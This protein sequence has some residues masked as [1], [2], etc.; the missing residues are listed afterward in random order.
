MEQV[1]SP[2][3]QPD[4]A[5]TTTSGRESSRVRR[6][7]RNRFGH[8]RA[9]WRMVF[10]LLA[11]VA[12]VIPLGAAASW[13]GGD[14]PAAAT[15]SWAGSWSWVAADLALI[16]AG[17]F[18]LKFVDRRPIRMLGIGFG[19]GWLR[20]LFV[21]VAGGLVLTSLLVLVLAG[22]GAVS[23]QVVPEIGASLAA[24]PLFLF[25]FTVAA[26]LEELL[27]RGYL[28]Q[29]LAEGS[30]R[31]I[32]AIVLC[33]P[34]TW[35]HA[36]NPDL[37]MVGV[38]NIFLAGVILVILYFQTRRLWLPIGFHLSWN[39]AQ[40]WFWGFDVSGIAIRD[41]LF[42]VTTTGPDFVTG[43]EFGLE[44]SILSTVA[45]VLIIAWLMVW[46]SITPTNDVAEM[47][48]AVPAGFG[49]DPQ[50]MPECAAAADRSEPEIEEQ[51]TT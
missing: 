22:M 47:W 7:F 16:L 18:L 27:F 50:A 51:L 37:T 45:F 9:G 29:A 40:S 23:L 4:R 20:E 12:L 35:A 21:G 49:L 6:V 15:F 30:R 10:Y 43:G 5:T 1:E 46:R 26:A 41:Q 2:E 11:S 13:L 8:W 25:I 39:L 36:D 38:S 32:A 42:A 17:L 34:F 48:A 33:V 28:L 31:W 14:Q 24:L 44:G 19:R 3:I